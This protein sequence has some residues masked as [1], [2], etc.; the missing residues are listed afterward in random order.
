MDDQAEEGTPKQ[1]ELKGKKPHKKN[2]RDKN[3]SNKYKGYEDLLDV[4]EDSTY[5]PPN[6]NELQL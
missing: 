2:K 6:G 5:I 1:N 4:E 3:Q